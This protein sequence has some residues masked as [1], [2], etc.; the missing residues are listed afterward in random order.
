MD[1]KQYSLSDSYYLIHSEKY[2]MKNYPTQIANFAVT[3]RCNGKCKNCNIWQKEPDDELSLDEINQ[4]F[5]V[6]REN[7][8]YVKSIQLTGGEPFL[9]EDLPEIADT[10]TRNIPGIMIWI[11][12]NGLIPDIVKKQCAQMLVNNLKLGISVSIDGISKVHDEVRGIPGSYKLA[13]KTLSNLI[14]LK[15]AQP[16]LKISI[17]F[18]LTPENLKE[19]PIV[20]RIAYN[21]GVDF[22]FRPVNRSDFYYENLPGENINPETVTCVLKSIAY[23]VVNQKGHLGALTMLQY[24]IGAQKYLNG[25]RTLSCTAGSRSFFLDPT[26]DI[27][28]CLVMN[29]K[30]GNIRKDSFE[31]IWGSE[32]AEEVRE[33][34]R[35]SQCPTCWL[36]CEVY[37]EL[38]KNKIGLGKTLI[39]SI[40]DLDG[41]VN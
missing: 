36:E 2:N 28:P 6:N 15:K 7:F 4:F 3:Y 17:G 31:Y 24:I 27:Y 41:L 39:Q 19:A 12:T 18:T 35:K 20:Q 21:N 13:R 1:S 8:R 5:T 10:V 37:R 38:M 25:E 22:S 9:R 23:N 30:L 16:K 33:K 32:K 14:S 40:M 34:I 26:G 11:P 29:Q